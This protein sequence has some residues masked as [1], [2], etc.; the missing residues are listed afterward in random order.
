MGH[1]ASEVIGIDVGT[2]SVK[3]VRIRRSAGKGPTR[4]EAVSIRPVEPAGANAAVQGCLSDVGGD[5][6]TVIAYG[7]DQMSHKVVDLPR[8]PRR[9]LVDTARWRIAEEMAFPVDDALISCAPAERADSTY[10]VSAVPRDTGLPIW[11]M[12]RESC[13]G[14]AMLTPGPVCLAAL[15]SAGADE[16]PTAFVEIGASSASLVIVKNSRCV[17][18]RLLG[19][20][21]ADLTQALTSVI[22]TDSG[23]VQLSDQEAED[24]KRTV[25]IPDETAGEWPNPTVSRSHVLSLMRPVL[26]DMRRQIIRSLDYAK[27]KHGYEVGSLTLFGGGAELRGLASFLSGSIGVPVRIGDPLISLECEDELPIATDRLPELALAVGAAVLWPEVPDLI[28]PEL[29]PS[30]ARQARRGTVYAAAAAI[31]SIPLLLCYGL[32]LRLAAAREEAQA[33]GLEYKALLPLAGQTASYDYVARL[34]TSRPDWRAGLLALSHVTPD[35]VTITD[36]SLLEGDLLISG[37][38]S[39]WAEAPA[40]MAT[41]FAY[42]L[43]RSAF[44]NVSLSRLDYS[45]TGRVSFQIRCGGTR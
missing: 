43:E 7:G 25:G 19:V 29:H 1:E 44:K 42:R 28:P 18:V 2:H 38:V 8:V 4:L 12:V 41:D 21:A 15:S 34:R 6:P 11:Q 16:P 22:S 33:A 17:F 31:V 26:E 32:F 9:E 5:C 35:E 39:D 37:T 45:D 27:R 13:S 40:K 3:C 14:A 24:L 23:S 20:T 36:V 30:V 10:L